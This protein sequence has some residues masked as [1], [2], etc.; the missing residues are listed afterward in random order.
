V[1][2]PPGAKRDALHQQ[3]ALRASTATTETVT[4]MGCVLKEFQVGIVNL[5]VV[6]RKMF[7][8]A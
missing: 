7:I 3:A 2:S 4:E 8:D 5:S 6:A 1:S